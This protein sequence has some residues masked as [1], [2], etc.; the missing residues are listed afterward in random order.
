MVIITKTQKLRTLSTNE[1]Q[2]L[3]KGAK[4]DFDLV[5]NQALANYLPKIFLSCPLVDE[6]CIKRQCISC[7]SDNLKKSNKRDVHSEDY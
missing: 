1:I 2:R 6:I 7:D 5:A 3:L 4:M